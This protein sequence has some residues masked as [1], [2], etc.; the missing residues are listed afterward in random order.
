MN[1]CVEGS[2]PSFSVSVSAMRL[3]VAVSSLVFLGFAAGCGG[4]GA[5]ASQLED[6]PWVLTE[7]RTISLPA[8]VAPSATFVDGTV[9][10]STGC[11]RFTASYTLDGDSLDIGTI[12]L[13]LMAC[14]PP[15]DAIERAYTT[16]LELVTTWSVDGEE[17]VLAGS[18]GAELLR[19]AVASLVGAWTVTG[20]L[21]SSGDAFSSPIAGT[22]ITA[23]FAEDGSLTGSGGCNDYTATYTAD[24][25]SITIEAPASTRKFCPDPEGVMDQ[26]AAYLAALE[27][28]TEYRLDGTTAE[29]LNGEGQRLVGFARAV[30]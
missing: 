10:G 3:T 9:S 22:E 24:R 27:E 28:A 17:L 5:D 14:P 12:G 13:T 29:L 8:G 2:N 26:E 21:S 19:Y 1:S 4:D 25:G 23:T 16:S 7:G 15:R 30:P 18:D 6:T 20:I 11:N